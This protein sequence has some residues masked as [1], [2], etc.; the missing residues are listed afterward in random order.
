MVQIMHV[1]HSGLSQITLA[2]SQRT[3]SPQMHADPVAAVTE[4]FETSPG[5]ELSYKA[6]GRRDRKP[7][8][9]GYLRQR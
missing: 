2:R 9:P 7:A 8:T 6:A 5:A 1:R 4:Q 3:D